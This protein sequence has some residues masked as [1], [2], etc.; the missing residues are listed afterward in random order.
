ML[1][2]ALIS[3]LVGFIVVVIRR[4]DSGVADKGWSCKRI[5]ATAA[6]MAMC[7][8]TFIAW[9]LWAGTCHQKIR[10]FTSDE[11]QNFDAEKISP[12]YT[13]FIVTI[14]ASTIAFGVAMNE[15]AINHTHDDDDLESVE[16]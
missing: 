10:D 6:M 11:I 8:F 2:L 7:I 16:I 15:C 3:A 5:T 14:V 12:P 1:V 13:G 9:A 4:N